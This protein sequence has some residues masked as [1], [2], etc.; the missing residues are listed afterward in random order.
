MNREEQR[1]QAAAMAM[2]GIL[3]RS[4]NVGV[5]PQSVAGVAVEM[6]D[7]LLAELYP[8]G[9][10]PQIIDEDGWIE[11]DP[12]DPVPKTVSAVR[13]KD[14]EEMFDDDAKA[15]LRASDRDMWDHSFRIGRCHIT[16]YKP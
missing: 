15:T 12:R 3:A 1:F 7:A 8:A 16:H 5:T 13:F 6:A 9:D 10:S 4:G 2:Q 11:H 14:G